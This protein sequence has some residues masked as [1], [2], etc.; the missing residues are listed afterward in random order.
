MKEKRVNEA[1]KHR[2]AKAQ[3]RRASAIASAYGDVMHALTQDNPL[4]S[5][6]AY[7]EWLAAHERGGLYLKQAIDA[8]AWRLSRERNKK[9]MRQAV[10]DVLAATWALTDDQI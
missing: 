2:T 1:A 8:L 3:P 7:A 5:Y 9:L 4:G 10:E 6:D